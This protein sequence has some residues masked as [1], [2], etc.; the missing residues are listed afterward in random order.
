MSFSWIPYQ[1]SLY[2][3]RLCGTVS[4]ALGIVG[5]VVSCQF[6]CFDHKCKLNHDHEEVK[7]IVI[8]KI[9]CDESHV[10]LQTK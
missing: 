3:R 9:D 5:Q 1:S 6:E 8:H 2:W 10:V 7:L 4:K